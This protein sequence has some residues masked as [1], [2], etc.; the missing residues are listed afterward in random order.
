MSPPP[1]LLLG[2]FE[3][4]N[5]ASSMTFYGFINIYPHHEKHKVYEEYGIPLNKD[6]RLGK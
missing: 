5:T 6:A 4:N 1:L 2:I 3:Q